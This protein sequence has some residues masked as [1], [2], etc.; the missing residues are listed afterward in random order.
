MKLHN[1]LLELLRPWSQPATYVG[2]AVIAAIWVSINFHLAVE[3]ERPRLAAIQDTSN[4]ARVFEEHIV[5]T[6]METDR[7]ILLLRTSYRAT[8]NFDLVNSLATHSQQNELL[9]QIRILGPDGVLLAA[10]TE[11]ISSAVDFSDRE[12]FQVH[13]GSKADDLF[14]SKP[15]LGRTTGKWLLQLSRG[16]RATDGSFQGVIGAS[17]NPSYLAQF[18]ETIDVGKD[19]VIFLAGLDGVVRASSGFKNDVVGGS[20]LSS[21]LFKK[22]SQADTGSFLTHGSQ[23]G[24]KRFV[25]YRVVKGFPLVVYVG[26]AEDEVLASYWRNRRLYFGAGTGLTALIVIG[27]AFAARYRRKL[28]AAQR[29]LEVTLENMNQGIMKV[30]AD[31]NVAFINRHAIEL[32]GLPDRFLTRHVAHADMLKFQWARG[33]F[34]ADGEALDSRVRANMKSQDVDNVGVYQRTR[35]NGVVLE[36][37]TVA[38]PDGGVVRTYTDV[39]ERR[40]NEVQIAHLLRHDDLTALA[41]RKLLKE[42]LEQAL[43]RM[44]RQ[45]EGFALFCLDLDGFKTVNDTRGHPAGDM[46]LRAVAERLSGCVREADTV[47]RLGGDEFAILQAPAECEED[48]EALAKRVL[49]AVSEPYHIGGDRVVIGTSIGIAMAPRD[50]ANMEELLRTADVALYHAKSKGPNAY[51]FSG[52]AIDDRLT[53]HELLSAVS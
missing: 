32:L 50:G 6:I 52:W 11:S 37:S 22:M 10:S 43:T 51:R 53:P 26:K 8:G 33:E 46:L 4:L 13:L 3:L 12:Y 7:T 14:I 23:D 48:V 27:A 19:G 17:L 29:E 36:I 42:R 41:N 47:A 35:P 31:R 40:R 25:S 16:V 21:Q 5:R 30:D 34:G 28:D 20:M 39:T 45:G 24:I 18:Y 1:G 49:K 2:V 38:L 9:T 15:V 44:Q